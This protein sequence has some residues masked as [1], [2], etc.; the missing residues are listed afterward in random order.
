M[1]TTENP[2]TPLPESPSTRDAVYDEGE[3]RFVEPV[4]GESASETADRLNKANKRGGRADGK[5][6]KR[7]IVREV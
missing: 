7:Y 1:T 4:P 6:G 5:R 3:L 2:A